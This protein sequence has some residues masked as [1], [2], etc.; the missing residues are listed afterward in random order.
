MTSATIASVVEPAVQL[1]HRWAAATAQSTTSAESRTTRRLAALVADPEG[2][3]LAVRFVDRVARPEDLHVAARELA[4]L[5]ASAASG[6]LSPVDRALLGLG[7]SVS[8][9]APSVVVPLAR[10]RLRQLVGHLVVDAE[11]PALATHLAHA[12]AD[13]RRLNINLL[14]EAVLG[15]SEA[16]ARAERTRA[17][18]DRPDVDY[19]SIK[20]SSLVSQLS[21]WD[22]Q[23]NVARVLDRL[24][25]LYRTAAARTPAAFVNLDMEEYKDLDLTVAVF[26]AI[27]SEA[28][29]ANLQTGLVLQAYLPDSVAALQRLTAFAQQRVARGGAPIKIRLVKGANLAMEKVEA[30]IHGWAQAPYPTK[31]D[32]DANYVRMLDLLLR[33]EVAAAVRTGVASHNLFDLALA[34]QL[35]TARGVS[36]AMDVEMLQ[37]M[38]PAQARAVAADVDT[39][40]PLILYTPVVAPKDFDVAVSYLVRRLEENAA[41]ENFVHAM[42]APHEGDDVGS[43][44]MVEQEARF[45]ASVTAAATLSAEPRRSTERPGTPPTFQ[46]TTDSDPALP[47]VREAARA[48]V[49]APAR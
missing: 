24:R 23:A 14:G 13:G 22:V 34:Y 40:G 12:K 20:V 5:S 10:R 2:L 21:H 45:R 48:W 29:F 27:C 3:D 46:N 8:R 25:P 38:A 26:E 19:V 30:E 33:P 42:F 15:E 41:P 18:L 43:A 16:A 4:R 35:A 9:L 49:S 11:D 7:A 28:E 39:H 1:A 37:G 36:P 17:L 6:F 31:A 44:P 32:V 47:A